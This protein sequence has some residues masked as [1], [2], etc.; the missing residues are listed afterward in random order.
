MFNHGIGVRF[1]QHV[2]KSYG[3]TAFAGASFAQCRGPRDVGYMLT[4][5]T[6]SARRSRPTSRTPTA[7][8]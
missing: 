2:M 8:C 4:M 1:L 3:C 5:G 6:D 7:W